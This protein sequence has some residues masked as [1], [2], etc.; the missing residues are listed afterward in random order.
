[1]HRLAGFDECLQMVLRVGYDASI[2]CSERHTCVAE[3]LIENWLS[4]RRNET[5]RILFALPI[6]IV[7][8]APKANNEFDCFAALHNADS[9]PRNE[10]RRRAFRLF[11]NRFVDSL[12]DRLLLLPVCNLDLSQY[13]PPVK[14][15]ALWLDFFGSIQE[16]LHLRWSVE[17][18]ENELVRVVG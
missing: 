12:N 16:P 1:M 4:R 10:A 17:R 14:S 18:V 5:A 15:L 2:L 6:T 13:R 9:V 7:A 3:Y 8:E 11:P